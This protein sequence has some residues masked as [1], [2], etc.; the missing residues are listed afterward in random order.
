[1]AIALP[2]L[3]ST[4]PAVAGGSNASSASTAKRLV[5]TGAY[6]GYH[7]EAIYPQQTGFGYEIPPTLEALQRHR[8]DFTIFSGFDHRPPKADG[9]DT[10]QTFL[11][12]ET[13]DS[14]SLDQLVAAK[15]GSTTR[16]Q[17]LQ[18]SAG[19]A[20]FPMNRDEKG[21][22]LPMISRPSVLYR[23][24][25]AIPEDQERMDYIL[26]SGGSALD[27]VLEDAK[28]LSRN[29]S[30][31]DR[32]KLD[33]Y[34]DALRE[35]ERRVQKRMHPAGQTMP[36]VDLSPPSYDPIGPSLMIEAEK[37]MY[38]LMALALEAD[39]SRVMTLFLG[40]EGQV[41]TIEGET[42]K[43][44]YH[45]LSHHGNDPE[46][47]AELV[48]VDREHMRCLAEFLD[49]LKSKTDADGRPLLETTLVLSGTGIGDANAHANNDLPTVVI[50]GGLKHGQ[51]VKAGGNQLL[52]DLYVTLL[53][54]L[55][56]EANRF[57]NATQNLNQVL[58]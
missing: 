17:S 11:T 13:R 34:F 21:K 38:D 27:M 35:V 24:L 20:K 9:H 12:G 8:N 33:E 48:K 6:L 49:Q 42:L 7:R 2:M 23:K 1:M 31:A 4:R 40:G 44:G 14:I 16:Y 45:A 5:C 37:M 53:Q 46:K 55:G 15:I 41:F 52:G 54:K 58:L 39:C 25:F 22:P 50:G 19:K 43:A 26:K 57:S 3:E 28:R 30:E 10:W 36:K 47:I 32:R 18:L 51:H 56:I 29:V